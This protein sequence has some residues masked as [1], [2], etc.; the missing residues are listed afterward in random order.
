MN[1]LRVAVIHDWLVISGGAEKVLEQLLLCFPGADV[2]SIINFLPEAATNEI[3]HGANVFTSFIQKFPL[4]K[5]FYWYYLPFMPLAI[6]QFDLSSYDIVISSSHVVAKGVITHPHQLHI[7]Y[8]HSPIRFAWDLQ[9]YYLEAFQY[10]YGIKGILARILFHYLR[11]WD[12]RTSNGVDKFAANSNFIA[13]RVKKAYGCSSEVIFPP[14]NVDYF[15]FE[16]SKEDY[17]LTAS[18]MN[19]FKKIGLIVEAFS[20]LPHKRL[21]VIGD[22][23]EFKKIKSKASSNV[24]FLEYQKTS[25]LKSYMQKAVA[26]IFAAP[27]DFGIIMAEAQSCGTPV[28]AYGRGG[29]CEIVRDL[30]VDK[31]TGVLFSQQTISSLL[32]AIEKF[33]ASA[34]LIRPENCRENA[35]R[36]H[37]SLFCQ[38][39]KSLVANEWQAFQESQNPQNGVEIAQKISFDS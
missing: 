17:Y 34:H 4:A 26:F 33:E 30:T 36:F 6:E 38:S 12:C 31:P 35:L 7:C 8:I 1:S 39:F 20:C 27:E 29:A 21:V 10:N 25:V 5:S 19:P 28:I 9:N 22:G 32:A 24:E 23:P 16:S 18:F 13:R 15:N 37:P 2:Y 3:L 11:L 14:V